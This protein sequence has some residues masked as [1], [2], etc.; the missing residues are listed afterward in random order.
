[1]I[2]VQPQIR[3]D[4]IYHN[5]VNMNTKLSIEGKVRPI[6][7]DALS[8]IIKWS[9]EWHH[10]I[11]PDVGL[12][13]VARRFGSVDLKTN[14]GESTYGAVGKGTGTPLASATQMEDEVARKQIATSSISGQTVHIEVFFTSTEANDLITKFA[15]F[16]ED[17]TAAADSG[18]LMEYADFATSFTKTSSDTL[19]IE[20]E[21]TVSRV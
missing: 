15:L 14:E 16:G 20:I 11:I 21:V 17:A 5:G 4:G 1:M 8:G 6:L 9:G 19:T 13:A 2:L 12:A 3:A 18:T 7:R 10:N